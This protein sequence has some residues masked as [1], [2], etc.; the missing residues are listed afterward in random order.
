MR[1]PLTLF[2]PLFLALS[3]PHAVAGGAGQPPVGAM[4]T[5]QM[6]NDTDVLFMEVMT[7]SNL[8]EIQTSQLALVQVQ[9]RSGESLRPADD[10]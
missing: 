10:Q 6:S 7:I 1:K 8:T 9:Q 4:S 5:A 3:A 2:L